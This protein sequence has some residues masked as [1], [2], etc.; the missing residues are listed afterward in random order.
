M[1]PQAL[2]SKATLPRTGFPLRA[3]LA[4]RVIT[5]LLFSAIALMVTHQTA[6][7]ESEHFYLYLLLAVLGSAWVGGWM[8]GLLASVVTTLGAFAWMYHT[9]HAWQDASRVATFVTMCGILC[10]LSWVIESRRKTQ[11]S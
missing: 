11:V 6:Q 2:S 1:A 7:L 8:A 3:P 10:W 5:P 4:L 9:A